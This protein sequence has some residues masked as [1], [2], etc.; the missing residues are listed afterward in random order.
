MPSSANDMM[1][2]KLKNWRKALG[3]SQTQAA[4]RLE[5]PLATLRNWE[6]GRNEPIGFAQVALLK[7]IN[8]TDERK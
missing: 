5:V 2:T 8:N 7:I 1:K 4:K 6:Q 3:L